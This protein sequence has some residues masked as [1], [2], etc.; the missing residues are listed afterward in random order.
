MFLDAQKNGLIDYIET[1]LLNTHM[2]CTYSIHG[3]GTVNVYIGNMLLRL[4][5]QN[6][7]L[8]KIK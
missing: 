3:L 7:H 1:V 6:R 4:R 8:L 5:F 2:F